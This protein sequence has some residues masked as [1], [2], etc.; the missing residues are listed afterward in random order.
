MQQLWFVRFIRIN[1]G[2]FL[3][4]L[5]KSFNTFKISHTSLN[6]ISI[7]VGFREINM[8]SG[9]VLNSKVKH[10]ILLSVENQRIKQMFAF[11]FHC[12]RFPVLTLDTFFCCAFPSLGLLAKLCLKQKKIKQTQDRTDN[13][14]LF[15]QI[16]VCRP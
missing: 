12:F 2:H 1:E 15:Q 14:F 10:Q 6:L 13:N 11:L 4:S 3:F 7:S 16:F 9:L 5:I 8:K